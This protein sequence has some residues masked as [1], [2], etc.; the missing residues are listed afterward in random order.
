M[1]DGDAGVHDVFVA[2]RRLKT[3]HKQIHKRPSNG[4]TGAD[5]EYDTDDN[6]HPGH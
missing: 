1:H 4:E 5:D 3:I 6:Q 2:H